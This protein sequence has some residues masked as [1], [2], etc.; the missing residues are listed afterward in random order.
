MIAPAL[1]SIATAGQP[2]SPPQPGLAFLA[3]PVAIEGSNL[4]IEPLGVS[5]LIRLTVS[6]SPELSRSFRVDLQGNLN[7]PPLHTPISPK[8]FLPNALPMRSGS[9]ASTA[10]ARKPDHSRL[11]GRVC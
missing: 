7:L 9:I 10:S 6:D 11:D 3:T 1:I 2:I 8:L 4:P 5:A